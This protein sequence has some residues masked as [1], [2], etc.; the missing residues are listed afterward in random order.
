[1]L[2]HEFA[3]VSCLGMI[4]AVVVYNSATQISDQ[5]GDANH[6]AE[7]ERFAESRFDELSPRGCGSTA[8]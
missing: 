4:Y 3:V 2:A 1:M 6:F 5:C 7:D 8:C